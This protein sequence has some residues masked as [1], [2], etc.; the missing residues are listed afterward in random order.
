VSVGA[1]LGLALVLLPADPNKYIAAVVDK[2][3]LLRAAK[4]PMLVV[5]AGS[6]AAFGIDSSILEESLPLDVVNYGLHER[7]GLRF[8]LSHVE[9]FLQ[10]GDV[11]LLAPEPGVFLRGTWKGDRALAEALAQFPGGFRYL[12][13]ADL[14]VAAFLGAAQVRLRRAAWPRSSGNAGGAGTVYSRSAFDHNGDLRGAALAEAQLDLRE[15][16]GALLA[17]NIDSEAIALINEFS[18][19]CAAKGVAVAVDLPPLPLE[20]VRGGQ[21]EAEQYVERLRSQ[22]HPPVLNRPRTLLMPARWFFDDVQHPNAEGREKRTRL[23]V[24]GLCRWYSDCRIGIDPAPL[25]REP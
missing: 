22:L 5:V 21:A 16:A 18:E 23:L 24:E 8:M 4:H 2:N 20:S 1:T 10:S 17:G 19:R 25:L 12:T 9:P 11:V 15:P 7:L 6:S 3:H 13:L 14:D